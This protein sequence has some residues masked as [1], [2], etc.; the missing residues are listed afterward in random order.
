MIL[1]SILRIKASE[2]KREAY[3][4]FEMVLSQIQQQDGVKQQHEILY[5]VA[6]S[7]VVAVS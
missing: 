7:A 1:E 5:T 6:G 3:I 4:H 2:E